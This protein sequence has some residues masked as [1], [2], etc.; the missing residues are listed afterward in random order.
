MISL[1]PKR[2]ALS[3]IMPHTSTI[4]LSLAVVQPYIAP[5]ASES[6]GAE[7]AAAPS[8]DTTLTAGRSD[9]TLGLSETM[10]IT[11]VPG[12]IISLY[13]LLYREVLM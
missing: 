4:A 7:S 2:H 1:V 3:S 11:T 5:A 12:T 6:A 9:E 10:D 13:L 8:S